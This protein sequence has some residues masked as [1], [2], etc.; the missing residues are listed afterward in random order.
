MKLMKAHSA[1]TGL[2]SVAALLPEVSA[3]VIAIRDPSVEQVAAEALAV[4]LA[5]LKRAAPDAPNGYV[6]THVNCPSNRPTIR[7]ATTISPNE[8]E[9]LYV[10]RN[11]TVS[12]MRDLLGRMNIT[13]LDTNSYIDSAANN[14]SAL[15]NIAI[16]GS[17]GGYRALMNYAGAV[18]AFDN[19]TSN[20]TG[21]GQLGG[22][23]QASTYLA[24]LSG[25]SW[26]VGSLFVNN[27]T[28]VENILAQDTGDNGGTWQFGNSILEG[29]SSSGL[30]ILNS[31]EY[32][33]DIYDTVQDKNDAGYETTIT[34][35][36]GRAL[37]YQL[38]NASMGGPAYTFSSIADDENFIAGNTPMPIFVADGRARGQ[39]VIDGN[40]TVYEMNPW[41]LGTF[42]PTTY[43][44]API[45]YL[46]SNF[47]DGV[48]IDGDMQCVRGFD[49]AGY[50]MGTSSSLFNQAFLQING[51]SGLINGVLTS[52]LANIG[53]DNDDIANY[54]NPFFGV[55][56]QTSRVATTDQL[57]LVDGGEDLQ[58]IPLHPLIQP[59]RHVDV[60][61][62]IDSSADTT[63]DN[64]GAN[65]PNGT[66]LVA[67]YARTFLD[68]SNGT[69]FPAVPD[70]QTFVNLGL[71]NR[72]TFFGCDSSNTT[73]MT[74][75]VVYLPNAPYVYHSNVSTYD[76]SYND[77][78]RNYII[79][80]G[81]NVATLG[82]GTLDSE[83]PTC[84]GCAILSRSL[85][86]TGTT[87]PDVCNQ[88]FQRYCWDGT[89]NSTTNTTYEPPY[90]LAK[91]DVLGFSSSGF[92]AAAPTLAL[93]VSA[94]ATVLMIM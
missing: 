11:N 63:A 6:P 81:Y 46:G 36:W 88:C 53:E 23:L 39:L 28:S 50:I 18:A 83:W 35:Y 70:Q 47:S 9:W 15:P 75:L 84:V 37:S 87:V 38:I 76:L 59:E 40:A 69:S 43:A 51:S 24:G 90:K 61:F 56:N 7:N 29:P 85:E 93:A 33:K 41:E 19:R 86:R 48:V 42:D 73:H 1:L 62:A 91:G 21:A 27:F 32:Y 3:N 52:I 30:Q 5:A 13:G 55:N 44:F 22:L 16:A 89:V 65:W 82:N 94:V 58:N 74:P 49:N 4:P 54:P 77:T 14:V 92:K 20:S 17:G 31:A 72:P 60:I 12:A 34:D 71:N 45:R 10:R 2:V 66:A 68:I 79:E 67:T 26:L 8:T 78:E 57:T 25:G 80:N 64:G